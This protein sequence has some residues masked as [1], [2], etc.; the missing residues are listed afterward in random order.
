MALARCEH[1]GLPRGLPEPYTDKH[2]PVNCSDSGVRCGATY[3]LNLA[4]I[5]LT[6]GEQERYIAGQR[7]FR[8]SC[9]SSPALLA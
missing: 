1:S 4:F 6:A 7:L 5:W 8:Y 9:R 2:T 3:C